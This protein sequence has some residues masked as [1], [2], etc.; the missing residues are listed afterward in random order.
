[1]K[2]GPECRT[3]YTIE[4]LSGADHVRSSAVPDR[5]GTRSP[6]RLGMAFATAGLMMIPWVLYLSMS[7]PKKAMDGH[8]ALDWVGLD[9]E[10][11]SAGISG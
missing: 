9:S 2:Q 11:I 6:R 8:W 7:L 10:V 1:M 4:A 5:P 3:T